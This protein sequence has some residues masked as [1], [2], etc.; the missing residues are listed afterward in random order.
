MSYDGIEGQK[1]MLFDTRRNQAY[2]EALK[3]VI[4]PDSVVLDLGAGMGI[5]GFLAAK[6]GA[7]RVYLVEPANAIDIAAEIAKTNEFSDRV[8]CFKGIIEEIQLPEPVDVIISVFTG[9]FL[10]EED[11]LPSLFYARDKYL[12]P[13]GVMIPQ[14]ATMEA[15]P[16]SAP[17]IYQ[18]EITCWSD[19]YLEIDHSVVRNYANQTIYYYGKEL[20]KAKYLAEPAK[21]LAMDFYQCKDTNCNVEVN[22]KIKESGLCHGWAGWFSMQLGDKWLSTAPGE[23]ALHWSKAFLPLDPPLK[24]K[25]GDNITLNLARPF[26]GDWSWRIKTPDTAQQHSTFFSVPMTLK[27]IKQFSPQYQPQ[28]D[29]KGKAALYVLDRCNGSHSIGQLSTELVKEYPQLFTESQKAL[30]FVRNIVSSF[31]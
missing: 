26:F 20:G 28:I 2:L 29:D 24:L 25:A 17:E 4:T 8:K 22:Y 31:S 23:P 18:Q 7:K 13:G 1:S 6:L 3:K 11:L 12:K 15:V 14:A 10:L 21:L 9:N 19:P 30:N 16:I 27:A 5:L